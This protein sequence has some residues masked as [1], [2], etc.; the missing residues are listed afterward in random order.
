MITCYD[1]DGIWIDGD[2]G[3]MECYCE[4]CRK[5]AIARFGSAKALDTPEFHAWVRNE[6]R[7]KFAAVVRRLKPSCL[8]SAGNTT[9]AVDFG[10]DNHMDYQ[11][12]DW[13][14]PSITGCR[15]ALPCA[16]TRR[17]AFPMRP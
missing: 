4:G 9:P 16:A 8:Y 11:S 6:F 15:K 5:L 13:F 1:P 14:S 12:G 10:F 3:C 17:S 2:W 7:R